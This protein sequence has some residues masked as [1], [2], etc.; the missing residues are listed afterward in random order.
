[1]SV[2]EKDTIDLKYLPEIVIS[3]VNVFNQ[4]KYEEINFNFS[5]NQVAKMIELTGTYKPKKGHFCQSHV[6]YTIDDFIHILQDIIHNSDDALLEDYEQ[7]KK[8][9]DRIVTDIQKQ[10]VG[11]LDI[12]KINKFIGG[13]GLIKYQNKIISTFDRF[14]LDLTNTPNLNRVVEDLDNTYNPVLID[15]YRLDYLSNIVFKPMLDV[16]LDKPVVFLYFTKDGRQ[17]TFS[18]NS[19]IS[20]ANTDD[21]HYPDKIQLHQLLSFD[22]SKQEREVLAL[23]WKKIDQAMQDEITDKM[24]EESYQ[25]VHSHRIN[26]ILESQEAVR[27][28]EIFDEL[29]DLDLDL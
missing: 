19:Q 29:T 10:N 26:I 2:E 1:M 8:D 4:G 13:L 11:L 16:D 7:T 28:Q 20:R 9:I 14:F 23:D 12:R 21:L 22:V 25:K 24:D 3:P 17:I 27:K 5:W 18:A 15:L 6:S